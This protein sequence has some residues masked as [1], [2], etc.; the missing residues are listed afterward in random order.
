MSTFLLKI[1][2]IVSM[3]IDHS[4]KILFHNNIYMQII[5]RISFPI[6]AWLIAHGYRHTRNSNKYFWRL[7]AFAFISQIP[8]ELAF[9]ELIVTQG[10]PLG[11]N[12]FFTLAAG[13]L[14]IIAFERFQNPLLKLSS[15]ALIGI[16]AEIFRFDYGLFGVL[17]IFAFHI[18]YTWHRAL[19]S[20]LIISLTVFLYTPLF[21]LVVLHS[22][23]SNLYWYSFF[24][25]QIASIAALPILWLHS[26]EQ[27][28]RAKWL[29]YL[30][31]PIHFLV[32]YAC[33]Y[34]L[35]F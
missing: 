12:V 8:Y 2:A 20:A 1:I 23:T 19:Q 21:N 34:F 13:L 16:T 15:V 29:F 26:G 11:L 5:G 10:W 14:A 6:F 28:Y 24:G 30:F 32:L 22:S 31:Y 25:T 27:G 3:A 35:S 33:V 7:V 18:S 9:R 4:G 17:L